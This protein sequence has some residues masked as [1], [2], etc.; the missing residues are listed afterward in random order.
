MN[1]QRVRPLFFL[2]DEQRDDDN[3]GEAD[4]SDPVSRAAVVAESVSTFRAGIT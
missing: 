3:Q 1:L 2:D 4:N